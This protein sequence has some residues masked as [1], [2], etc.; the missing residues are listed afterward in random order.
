MTPLGYGYDS[1]GY[2]RRILS[3]IHILIQW[4]KDWEAD[5][6]TKIDGIASQMHISCY[7]D[8]VKQESVKKHIVK[9]LEL[10]KKSEKLCKIS[11]CDWSSDV[12][13]SDLETI[14][15]WQVC[16]WIFLT[17]IRLLVRLATLA[18]ILS[19]IHISGY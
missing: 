8:P 6:V 5:G 11:E 15:G 13:S 19:L 10:M 9:M 4:I 3:L 14:I 12:C 1:V 18:H 7:A 2:R 16:F 17:Y